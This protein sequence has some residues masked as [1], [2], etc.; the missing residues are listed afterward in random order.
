VLLHSYVRTYPFE[1]LGLQPEEPVDAL[2][3][4]GE[5]LALE[6]E[7]FKAGSIHFAED[8]PVHHWVIALLAARVLSDSHDRLRKHVLR[9]ALTSEI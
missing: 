6:G 2:I 1:L 3:Q 5:G 9:K 4:E 8:R 7:P